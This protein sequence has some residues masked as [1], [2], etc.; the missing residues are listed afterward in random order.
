MS[1]NHKRHNEESRRYKAANT[2]LSGTVATFSGVAVG[3]MSAV[4][5][6]SESTDL[7]AA[8]KKV[9]KK[10]PAAKKDKVSKKKEYWTSETE[11]AVKEY[12]ENDFNFYQYKIDKHKEEVQK[13]IEKNKTNSRVKV[14]EL[15]EDFILINQ[16]M[17]DYTSRP[18]II[19]KKE[20]IFRK[21]IHKPLTRLVENII[22]SFRLF[23]SGVDVKTLHNDCMSHV[24]EKFCNFDPEQNTKSF[25]FYGTV[26]KHYLQN[27][28]KEVDKNTR[29]TLDYDSHSDEAEELSSFELDEE[30]DLDS[31]L[32]LFNHIIDIFEAELDRTDISINDAK[33]A[34]AIVDIFKSHE[35]MGVYSKS[36]VYKLIKEH[37]NL[38]TKDIT[39]SLHRFKILYRLKK[40][41]FVERHKDKYYGHDDDI[42]PY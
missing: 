36:S 27:K 28:K 6:Y 19:R 16:S 41:E 38:E 5:V 15:D 23:R 30:S 10:K 25:S 17:V 21:K 11:E 4:T 9:L 33:V 42:F 20:E 7:E 8:P 18:E 37:T 32:A 31:S 2:I 26:A 1:S 34:E 40:Q 14:L 3:T 22:F 13:S 29:V 24:I 39:Y 35:L 12:L